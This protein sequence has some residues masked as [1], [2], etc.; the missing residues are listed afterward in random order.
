MDNDVSMEANWFTVDEDAMPVRIYRGDA[1]C[2][3]ILDFR[4]RTTRDSAPWDFSAASSKSQA[5]RVLRATNPGLLACEAR[6]TVN[7]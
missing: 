2:N 1:Q 7:G 6:G 3:S 4:C 5:W